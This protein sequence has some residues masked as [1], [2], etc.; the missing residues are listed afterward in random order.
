MLTSTSILFSVT[1]IL[2][3]VNLARHRSAKHQGHVEAQ[4][5]QYA[6]NG[7]SA[8]EMKA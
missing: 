7:Q 1:M 3:I 4:N 2:F 5:G 8:M 6:H